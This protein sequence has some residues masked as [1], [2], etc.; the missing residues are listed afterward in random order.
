[1]RTADVSPPVREERLTLRE[2]EDLFGNSEVFTAAEKCYPGASKPDKH[3][4]PDPQPY[5]K[6]GKAAH[7]RGRAWIRPRPMTNLRTRQHTSSITDTVRRLQAPVG[8][9]SYAPAWRERSA[10]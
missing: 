6:S 2:A 3:P 8:E 10:P 7:R 9:V 5:D 1:V 4:Q